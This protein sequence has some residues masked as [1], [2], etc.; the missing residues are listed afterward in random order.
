MATAAQKQYERVGATKGCADHDRDLVQELG[1]RLNSVW[2]MD[3]YLAN[4][5]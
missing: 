1:K 5:E 2:R 4:A 3:Q